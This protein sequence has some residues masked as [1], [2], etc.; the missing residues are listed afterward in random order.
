MLLIEV[1]TMFLS[2]QMCLEHF[3]DFLMLLLA[4]VKS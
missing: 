1:L 3:I 2:I 4:P